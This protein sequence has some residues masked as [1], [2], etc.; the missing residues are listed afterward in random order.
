MNPFKRMNDMNGVNVQNKQSAEKEVQRRYLATLKPFA[1]ALRLQKI[2]KN[3]PLL[4]AKAD[5]QTVV[6]L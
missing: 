6:P 2:E 3:L 1:M 5:F 4:L